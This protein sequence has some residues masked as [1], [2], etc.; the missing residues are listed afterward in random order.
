MSVADRLARRL[1]DSAA[2]RWPADLRDDLTRDWHAELD[3]SRSSWHALT[4]AGSL[5]V[6]PAVE[7][8]DEEPVT[9]AQRGAG[10]ARTLSVPA[11]LTLLAGALVNAAHLAQGRFGVLAG[12]VALTAAA[13]VMVAVGGRTT[14]G[15]VVLLGAAGYAFLLAGNQV[16]VMPFMGWID[17]GPAVLAWTVLTA[18]TV[19]VST[20]LRVT[21]RTT[22]A[23]VAAVAGAVLALDVA[24]AAGSLHAAAVL[25]V[26]AASAP[27]WFPLAL[28]PGGI[29]DFGAYFA[30][31]TATFGHLQQTGPAFHASAVLLGNASA[32]IGPLTMCSVAVVAGLVRRGSPRIPDAMRSPDAAGK[33]ALGVVAGLG[34]LAIGEVLRRSG[35]A[36]ELT[37]HQLVDNSAVFGFGFLAHPAGRL[38]VALLIGLLVAHLGAPVRRAT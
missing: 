18:A 9:W 24:A 3:A 5:A 10:W 6:S 11:A 19:R 14:V 13:A 1:V 12:A 28:L 23:G 17:I 25:G 29:A 21:G 4:F 34:G 7:E 26:N 38:A 35:G 20:S 16:A 37:L 32:M 22:L 2:R 33:V 27:S 31:G 8:A 30:D 15:R 36:T